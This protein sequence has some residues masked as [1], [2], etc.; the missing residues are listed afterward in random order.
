MKLASI[1]DW[2]VCGL[3]WRV[4]PD[5]SIFTGPHGPSGAIFNSACVVKI[6]DDEILTMGGLGTNGS[7]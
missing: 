1:T 4:L 2:R 3:D 6:N 7:G 5:G